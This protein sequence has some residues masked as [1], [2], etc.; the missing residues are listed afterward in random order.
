M[1]A[2]AGVEPGGA[3]GGGW[4]GERG[5]WGGVLEHPEASKAWP[6]FG[7]TTPPCD[8]GW[9]S[10]GDWQGWTCR[11]E[12]GWYGHRARKATWLY[13]CSARARAPR[14]PSLHWGESVATIKGT[15]KRTGALAMMSHAKR[16]R[17]PAPFRDLLL[18]IARGA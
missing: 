10:A 15:T 12:Q 4:G 3:A 18:S 16:K 7:L 13:V 5:K 1:C 2:G 14:L 11:V 8:G 9:I 6:F 17:T